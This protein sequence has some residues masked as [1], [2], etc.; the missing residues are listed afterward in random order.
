M[1]LMMGL[2]LEHLRAVKKVGH[3]VG[4]MDSNLERLKGIARQKDWQ[5]ETLEVLMRTKDELMVQSSAGETR[6]GSDVSR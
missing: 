5:M 4:R 3:W 2:N 6:L 1:A